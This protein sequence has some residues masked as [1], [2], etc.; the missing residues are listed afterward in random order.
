VPACNA[1]VLQILVLFKNYIEEFKK[2]IMQDKIGGA[3]GTNG[4]K[5]KSTQGLG[6]DSWR[7]ETT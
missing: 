7:K 2:A 1:E 4:G 5:E 3:C 6:G